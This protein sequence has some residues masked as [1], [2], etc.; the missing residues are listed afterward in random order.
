MPDAL[1]LYDAHALRVAWRR[2]GCNYGAQ[3]FS[4]GPSFCEPTTCKNRLCYHLCYFGLWNLPTFEN[5][6]KVLLSQC[7][8]GTTQLE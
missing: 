3:D 4:P 7:L 8:Q 2:T 5:R 1:P 6:T